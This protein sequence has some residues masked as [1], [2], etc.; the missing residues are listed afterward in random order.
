MIAR[1][2]TSAAALAGAIALV[3]AASLAAGASASPKLS[4]RAALL[5]K[6]STT[7]WQGTARS[8]QLGGGTIALTG[9]V[10]FLPKASE[11]PPA[12]SLR[13]RVTFKRGWMR[14]CLRN[15]VYLRPGERQVWDG[16]GRVT[17]TSASLARYRGLR[18]HDGG[19]TPAADLTRATPFSFS[20]H[21]VSRD[22]PN[23][24][25]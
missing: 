23:S 4:V 3:P 1:H 18:I 12:T 7:T 20:T 9:K 17:S 10:V 2:R 24:P 16:P 5:T 15:S 8:P 13:F 11:D 19:M 21:G 22:G 6:T 25:C 14:G